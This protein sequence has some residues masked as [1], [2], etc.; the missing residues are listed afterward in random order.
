MGHLV[1]I[2][3]PLILLTARIG[4]FLAVA[5]V[6]GSHTAPTVA[7]GGLAIWIAVFF[8]FLVPP[9]LHIGSMHWMQA[10]LL[11]VQESII[12]LA[13]GLAARMIFLAI[14]QGGAMIAQQM[15]LSDAGVIDP[16]SGEENESL[17]SLLEATLTLAFLAVGGL[18]VLVGLLAR[19]YQAL[20]MGSGPDATGLA[21]GLVA[22]GTAML[23]FGLKLAAPMLAGFLVL[24]VVLAILAR[25]LPEMNILFESYPLRVGLGLFI[26]AA[27]LPSMNHVV[28]E[29][30]GFISRVM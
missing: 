6:L 8:A 30:A 13:I 14:Q 24:A 2:L 7:K 3:F 29:L 16:M 9:P 27:M 20:P 12:G 17:G 10:V 23:M 19:S 26:T 1:V 25:V 5:P 18:H 15:G 28:I 21:R 11:V 22:A 4:A